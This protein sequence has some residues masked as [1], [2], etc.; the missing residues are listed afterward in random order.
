MP[1]FIAPAVI[2]AS[3]FGLSVAPNPALLYADDKAMGHYPRIEHVVPRRNHL[4]VAVFDDFVPDPEL[5]RQSALRTGFGTWRPN[6]GDIGAEFFDGVNFWGDHVHGFRA[7]IAKLGQIIPSSTLFRIT[8]PGMERALIHSDREYG[9]FTAV[10]Y[11]SHTPPGEFSGTAFYRHRETGMTE[12]PLLS[13]LMKDPE[14]F[15]TI[16]RDMDSDRRDAWEPLQVVEAKWNRCV[17]FAAP[18]IHCRVPFT[19]YG[20]GDDDSRLAWVCHFYDP[21][22]TS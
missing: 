7:L 15:E 19:G 5:M 14:L 9:D 4:P 11:L 21:R 16:K 17:V 18:L 10:L 6:K 12:M 1:P 2:K 3:D 20:T 13:E 8:R 22:R